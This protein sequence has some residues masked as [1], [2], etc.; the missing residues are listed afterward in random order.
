MGK[1]KVYIYLI[2]HYT[3]TI[4]LYRCVLSVLTLYWLENVNVHKYFILFII[5]FLYSAHYYIF[6]VNSVYQ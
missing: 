4:I 2:F 1:E 6:V 5:L 3:V